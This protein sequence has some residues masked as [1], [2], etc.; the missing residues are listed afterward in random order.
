[1]DNTKFEKWIK[2]SGL[3]I[4]VL[5]ALYYS[6]RMVE[7]NFSNKNEIAIILDS[8][9]EIGNK[10]ETNENVLDKIDMLF[11]EMLSINK[12]YDYIEDFFEKN[13][14]IFF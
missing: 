1:M 5:K 2:F 3:I 12:Y 8:I 4:Q 10:Y 6:I 9:F 14:K 13:Y 11:I 7:Q